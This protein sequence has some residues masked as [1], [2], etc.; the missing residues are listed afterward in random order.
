MENGKKYCKILH[1][2]WMRWI[3]FWELIQYQPRIFGFS[4]G[5]VG[6]F[7]SAYTRYK[8]TVENSTI[9]SHIHSNMQTFNNWSRN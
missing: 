1:N 6:L 3:K 4:I 9:T 2:Q 7:R 8:I 5:N